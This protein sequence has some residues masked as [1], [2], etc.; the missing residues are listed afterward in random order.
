[1]KNIWVRECWDIYMG[2]GLDRKWLEGMK[3]VWVRECW[4]IY[5]GKGLD[6]K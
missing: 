1:M 4:S 3:N 2:K 5:T 6:R